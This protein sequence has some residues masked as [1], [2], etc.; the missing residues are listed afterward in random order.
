MAEIYYDENGVDARPTSEV[1]LDE[2]LADVYEASKQYPL[3]VLTCTWEQAEA[4]GCFEEDAISFE[5]AR[6][7]YIAEIT[8]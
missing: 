6:Q 4:L 3:A 7:G 2:L 8:E 1:P 5:D